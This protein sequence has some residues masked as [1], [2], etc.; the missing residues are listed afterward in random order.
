MNSFIF[1][2]HQYNTLSTKTSNASNLKADLHHQNLSDIHCMCTNCIDSV[3]NASYYFFVCAK[4]TYCRN[5]LFICYNAIAKAFIATCMTNVK[6][7]FVNVRDLIM[8]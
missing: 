4:N 6:I 1:G 2:N 5:A 7:V 8:L 3:K